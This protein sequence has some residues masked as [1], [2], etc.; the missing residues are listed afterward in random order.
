MSYNC[1]VADQI[2]HLLRLGVAHGG[3]E[4]PA[5]DHPLAG[6][7]HRSRVRHPSFPPQGLI[8]DSTASPS[9]PAR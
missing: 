8:A 1:H 9:P 6:Q 2:P 5:K 4:N 3:Q 7:V